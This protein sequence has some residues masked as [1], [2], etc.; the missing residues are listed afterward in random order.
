MDSQ[1]SIKAEQDL[2]VE[3]PCGVFSNKV[4]A[5]LKCPGIG[6]IFSV[7]RTRSFLLHL[8]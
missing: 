3:H 4:D 7:I 2:L 1:W 8:I 6:A 5:D